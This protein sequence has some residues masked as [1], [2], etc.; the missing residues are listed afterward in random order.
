L[1]N[2]EHTREYRKNNKNM[3]KNQRLENHEL[4]KQVNI[5]IKDKARTIKKYEY[6]LSRSKYE[7][8]F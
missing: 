8:K 6:N 4:G 2:Q 7:I 1:K 3:D 5:K